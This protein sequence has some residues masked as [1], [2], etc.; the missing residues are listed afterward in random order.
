MRKLASIQKILSI[1]PIERRDQIGLATVEGWHVIVRYDQFVPGDLCVYVEIDS[2]M[3]ERPEFEFLR[4]KKFR[5]RTLKMA[6]VLSQGICF[7]LSILPTGD[8]HE[9]DDVTE[10]LGVTKYDEYNE[11]MNER[12]NL[13]AKKS[14]FR[15]FMFRHRV[16]RPLARLIW[17]GTRREKTGF[18]DEVV[19]TD[20][21][22]IQNIPW[23]VNGKTKEYTY[24]VREKIDGQSS[25]FLLRRRKGLSA[26]WNPF[27]F[28]VCSRNIR[29]GAPDNSSYWQVA[30]QYDI[31][32]VLKKLIRSNAW[33]C[34]QGECIGPK[35]Q[36][37]PYKVGAVDLYCFN[38]IYPF[39][40]VRGTEAEKEVGVYGLKWVPMVNDA[41]HLPD[42]VDEVLTYA[43]GKSALYDTLR[44]GIVIRDYDH[45]ISFKAVSNAYLLK[46][47][48]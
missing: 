30:K 14:A 15:Q 28:V 40:R 21:V 22:R 37:N 12:P 24:E 33:V 20:E 16:T 18:P 3:P 48:K 38:L 42:T 19:K 4:S 9:G 29:L 46:H 11:A 32:G 44:E 2:I 39:G 47:N 45:G 6:G 31:E 8:Y 41:Y 25:T 17:Q 35:I 7:P 27:E 1:D 5:I 23:I 26:L 34:I 36:N 10:I 43:E 13:P